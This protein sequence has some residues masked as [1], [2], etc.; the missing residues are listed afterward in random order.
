ML[1]S[2]MTKIEVDVISSHHYRKLITGQQL[3]QLTAS[4]AVV[5]KWSIPEEVNGLT[6]PVV[7]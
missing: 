2:L 4:A 5:M 7:T 3:Q 1:I 6:W